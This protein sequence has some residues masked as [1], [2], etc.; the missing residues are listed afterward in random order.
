MRRGEMKVEKVP[1]KQNCSDLLTH[2]WTQAEAQKFLLDMGVM[3]L[4]AL[5]VQ[6][7]EGAC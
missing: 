3:R 5:E 2:H 7:G 4:T 6:Q 1:R